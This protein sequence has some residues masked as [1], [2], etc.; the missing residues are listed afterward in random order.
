MER[1]IN[2]ENFNPRFYNSRNTF[3][4]SIIGTSDC[5]NYIPIFSIGNHNLIEFED[6]TKVLEY[7]MPITDNDSGRASR[8]YAGLFNHLKVGVGILKYTLVINSVEHIFYVVRGAMYDPE[9]N[10][11]M[12]LTINSEYLLNTPLLEII[13][14]TNPKMFTL[15]ISPNFVTNPIYKNVYKKFGLEWYP[16]CR[17][18]GID[19]I[20]TKEIKDWT[21]INNFRVPHFKTVTKL[22]KHLKEVPSI[23][24]T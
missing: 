24:I 3:D 8:Q 21:F 7:T 16:I 11:L 17:E 6:N 1:I 20:E 18:V 9:G 14:S 5:N 2:L 4:T 22:K 19:I 10:F 23:L 15:F 12:S 13:S